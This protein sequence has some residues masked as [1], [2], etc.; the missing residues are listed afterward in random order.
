MLEQHAWKDQ[1][2][3]LGHDDQ[4]C[5]GAARRDAYQ[6]SR[7]C[8]RPDNLRDERAFEFDGDLASVR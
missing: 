4:K 5:R 1:P 8:G 7:R 3:G 2:E 6:E